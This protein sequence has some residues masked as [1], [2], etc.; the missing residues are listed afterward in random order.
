[1]AATSQ[2]RAVKDYRKRLVDRGMARF[3]VVGRSADRDLI[4]HLARQLASDDAQAAQLRATLGERFTTEAGRKGGIFAALRRSPLVGAVVTA[5]RHLSRAVRPNF[6]SISARHKHH[7][8][9]HEVV[10][11]CRLS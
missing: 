11:V 5:K 8:Q 10:A 1:M 4:R 3:E 7:Q 2:N 9:H 6:T